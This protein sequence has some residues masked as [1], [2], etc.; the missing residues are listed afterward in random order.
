MTF[1]AAPAKAQAS[2]ATING[3]VVDSSGGVMA[4][5]DVK[6]EVETK[7]RTEGDAKIT[8]RLVRT[9]KTNKVGQFTA[10]FLPPGI[11]VVTATYK[12][13]AAGKVEDVVLNINDQYPLK[14]TLVVGA[15]GE[16]VTVSASTIRAS[17]APGVGTV[18]DR[19][20]VENIPLNGRS[21]QSLM[22]AIPGVVLTPN[23][24]ISAT[25]SAQFSISGQRPT[26][27]SFMV[28]GVSAN[29]G[30]SGRGMIA[31]PSGSGQ[32]PGTTALG[33]T[34]SL[35]SLDALQEFRIETSSYGA[36][37]G[38]TPGGQI[39]L[40]TRSG[41]NAFSGSVSEYF[42]DTSMNAN[43][44]FANSRNQ[45][46]AKMRQHLFGGVMGGPILSNRL[47]FF[48]SYEGLRLK[49]PRSQIVAVPTP[50][51]RAEVS[52]ALKPYLNA[53]PLPN[54]RILQEGVAELAASYSEP[55]SF[56]ATSL[57]L[58]WQMSSALSGF[59]RINHAPSQTESRTNSLSTVNVTQVSNDAI[60]GG[61]TWNAT[62][63]FT[64]D[65][66]MNLTKNQPKGYSRLDA[67]KGA[68]IPSSREIF[69]N[70][71]DPMSAG[72]TFIGPGGISFVWGASGADVQRQ[73]NTV[74]NF[75]FVASSHQIKFGFD[76][77][78]LLPLMGEPGGLASQIMLFGSNQS[79]R[80]SHLDIYLNGIEAEKARTAI[81]ENI[82][83]YIQDSWRLRRRTTI[84][85]GIRY[86]QVPSPTMENDNLIRTVSGIDRD[87][88]P[89][90]THLTSPGTPILNGR[91]PSFAPRLAAAYQLSSRTGWETTI[92][93][94]TGVFYD[95]GLG[96]IANAFQSTY[97]F[98]GVFVSADNEF[99][100]SDKAQMPPSIGVNAPDSM[101]LL[102]PNLSLPYSYQW[103][104]VWEQGLGNG[105]TL[106]ISYQGALGRRLL[107][108]TINNV[109]LS[110]WPGTQTRLSI[111]RNVGKSAYRSLQLQ[112]RHRLQ[113]RFQA[114]M[115]YTLA[116]AR[117][118][119]SGDSNRFPDGSRS[120]VSGD[121]WSASDFDVRHVASIALSYDT[122]SEQSESLFGRF[123]CNWGTDLMFRAQSAFPTTVV[124]GNLPG[125]VT[126]R[127]DVVSG[128]SL[129][130]SDPLVPG[131][132]RLNRAA[133]VVPDSTGRQGTSA[134][135]SLRG[136]PAYQVDLAVRRDIRVRA[137]RLQLRADVFNL[138]NRPN[139]GAILSE[140]NGGLFGQPIRMLNQ[141]L[142]GLNALYQMGGPRSIQA[143]MKVLF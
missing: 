63:H 28:D 35:V 56:D 57:R 141:S 87:P 84:T 58:D 47:F 71:R 68:V 5:V 3:T 133:F 128:Q 1:G 44:W 7:N 62:P 103:N 8:T 136:F 125:G 115:S 74:G 65:I 132:R 88:P 51:L 83:L 36:E 33:G 123:S 17:T 79:L 25:S 109:E 77:R 118:N 38:R 138:L 131:G 4:D 6:I 59:I 76:Y 11:Y 54:G 29:T 81:F 75:V 90:S 2:S 34:N 40:V 82:S 14:I 134:R 49:Q 72:M 67:F 43:D 30:M 126:Q 21:L 48:G 143:S 73:L 22:Q 114:L 107:L 80:D 122:A 31:G 119:G 23:A 113:N 69:L 32:T 70:G 52:P 53:M 93:A 91:A 130:V 85:Y 108:T 106:S 37:F 86:E 112:Y 39:S 105:R 97:P 55:S 135:N 92:R 50:E 15:A 66:R 139:F 98:V 41:T 9:L 129:Y 95:V 20:F 12:G 64:G 121:E 27:N 13:F 142:G 117:D 140:L 111:Q 10:P 89:V 94:S 102:D 60:T 16:E 120:D 99:P 19:K 42:R 26:A 24:G 127:A 96:D 18:I 46:K 61:I 100:L 104:G 110:E 116:S 101:F 137:I 78:R 124:V 45:P